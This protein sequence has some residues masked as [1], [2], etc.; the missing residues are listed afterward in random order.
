MQED[1]CKEI[2]D[3]ELF[4]LVQFIEILE[5]LEKYDKLEEIKK[6]INER[7]EIY[8]E[9]ARKNATESFW[10]LDLND[11]SVNQKIEKASKIYMESEKYKSTL[12]KFK[13]KYNELLNRFSIKN[14]L[15]EIR[16]IIY[17][18]CSFDV[19][20]AYKIGLIDGLKV[21]ALN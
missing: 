20:L 10:S 13:M 6:D 17:E 9:Y 2:Q 15:D 11:E 16:D 19:N 18:L 4:M 21:N 3:T 14:E 1:I 5:I 7:K 12:E 8:L